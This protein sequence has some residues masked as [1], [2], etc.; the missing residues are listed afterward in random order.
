MGILKSMMGENFEYIPESILDKIL[1]I[2][3]SGL[4]KSQARNLQSVKGQP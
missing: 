1:S 3:D 4:V 2:F